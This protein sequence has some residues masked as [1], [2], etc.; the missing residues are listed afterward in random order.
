MC[1]QL[2]TRPLVHERLSSLVIVFF[3]R[4]V[5]TRSNAV[6]TVGNITYAKSLKVRDHVCVGNR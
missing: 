5:H 1:M 6:H 2:D 3:Q 4:A